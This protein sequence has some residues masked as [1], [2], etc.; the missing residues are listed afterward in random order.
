MIQKIG[1]YTDPTTSETK[2]LYSIFG[3]AIKDAEWKQVG[4]RKTS[5]LTITVSVGREMPLVSIKM[6]SYDADKWA[7][8]T[9]GATIFAEAV[10]NVRMYNGKEYRDYTPL[11]FMAQSHD[12]TQEKKSP[13]KK[14]EAEDVFE[15]FTDIQGDLPF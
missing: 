15:G 10:E 8:V 2:D 13:P 7:D 11:F 3:K 6:W 9:K 12:N 5:M 1:Q 14:F 4:Q